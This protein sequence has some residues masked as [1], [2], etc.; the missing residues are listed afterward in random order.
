MTNEIQP[1]AKISLT[2]DER[3]TYRAALN[4]IDWG[5]EQIE[6]SSYEFKNADFFK[7]ITGEW[8]VLFS[9]GSVTIP[10]EYDKVENFLLAR[11]YKKNSTTQDA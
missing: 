6:G 11:F 3:L 5:F 4:L 2:V 10:V 1:I 8:V 7:V 9:T